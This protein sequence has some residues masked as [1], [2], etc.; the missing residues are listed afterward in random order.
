MTIGEM[1]KSNALSV[2]AWFIGDGRDQ[3]LENFKKIFWPGK[4]RVGV[5]SSGGELYWRCLG[6]MHSFVTSKDERTLKLSPTVA[7]Q[8]R[9]PFIKM[10]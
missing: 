9:G 5:R 1:D 6:A 4:V 2:E 8:N 7:I 10:K 3:S